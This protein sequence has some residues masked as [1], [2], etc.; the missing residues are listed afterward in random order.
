MCYNLLCNTPSDATP[1]E[2]L[3]GLLNLGQFH[4]YGQAM[5]QGFISSH[6]S[7]V[8][9]ELL[10][11]VWHAYGLDWQETTILDE[12]AVPR[13]PIRLLRNSLHTQRLLVRQA[14]FS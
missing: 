14:G 7:R 1:K 11:L 13:D 8:Y 2:R 4:G 12:V 9:P 3:N 10:D 5:R 6:R